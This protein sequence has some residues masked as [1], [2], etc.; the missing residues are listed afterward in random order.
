M[1]RC[2]YIGMNGGSSNLVTYPGTWSHI[3]KLKDDLSTHGINLPM[4]FKKK[5]G[6]GQQTSFWQDN[7]LGGSSFKDT[8]P[9]LYRLETNPDCLVSE[10][11]SYGIN[12]R[13]NPNMSSPPSIDA[14][15][16]VFVPDFGLVLLPPS[17]PHLNWAWRRH[18]RSGPKLDELVELTNLLAQLNLSD[19]VDTWEF[20]I[21]STRIFSA[22]SMRNH[23][24]IM[25][26]HIDSHP[27]RWN[28][29]LPIK[30][31]I[32]TWRV[33][34]RRIP[35]R[36]NLDR[37]GIDLDSVHCPLCDEDLES[38]DHIFVSCEIASGI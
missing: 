10:R 33:I 37:R 14:T 22:K 7:W 32:L 31:N 23:I 9:C 28:K 17:G 15:R 26:N 29:L 11:N 13:N 12:L 21:D 2:S 5:I 30:V 35:T 27:T 4:L 3:R 34:N 38:E 25:S 24:T 16:N 8:F 18:I 20:S 6:N 19:A 1:R 36:T